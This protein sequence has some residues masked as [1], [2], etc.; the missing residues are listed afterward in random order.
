M[1]QDSKS[2]AMDYMEMLSKKRSAEAKSSLLGWLYSSELFDLLDLDKGQTEGE[3]KAWN[4]FKKTLQSIT[5]DAPAMKRSDVE[6]LAQDFG[7]E[8]VETGFR[9]GFHVAMRLCMEGMNGSVR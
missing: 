8:R 2:V 1:R 4:N 6:D 3:R 9:I 5:A 7:N